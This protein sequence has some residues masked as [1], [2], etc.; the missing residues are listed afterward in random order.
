MSSRF[1]PHP[2]KPAWAAAQGRLAEKV[3]GRPVTML[4]DIPQAPKVLRTGVE[5]LLRRFPE[6]RVG[7][8]E[9]TARRH[10]RGGRSEV[11]V[12]SGLHIQKDK[13]NLVALQTVDYLVAK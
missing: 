1:R 12:T 3:A 4:N 5:P 2:R 9:N 6:R 8:I 11:T 10:R 13:E 7:F